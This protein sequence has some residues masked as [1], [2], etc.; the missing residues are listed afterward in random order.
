MQQQE[1]IDWSMMVDLMPVDFSMTRRGDDFDLDRFA[2]H[3]LSRPNET[4]HEVY[5]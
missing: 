4:E 2:R 1:E 3:E 5:L